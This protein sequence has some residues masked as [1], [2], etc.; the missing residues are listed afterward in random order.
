MALKLTSSATTMMMP[1][2]AMSRPASGRLACAV[3]VSARAG[4]DSLPGK[5]GV[6]AKLA[7]DGAGAAGSGGASGAR[8]GV[9]VSWRV[10]VAVSVEGAA[11]EEGKG[12]AA[13]PRAP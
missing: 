1:L 7:W 5:V 9:E 3:I 6:A 8:V 12:S 10:S 13:F 11:S 2:S 4:A